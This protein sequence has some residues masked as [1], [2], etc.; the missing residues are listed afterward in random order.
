MATTSLPI[1]AESL[2]IVV[3]HQTWLANERIV[4]HRNVGDKLIYDIS[5]DNPWCNKF[6]IHTI[7]LYYF[8]SSCLVAAQIRTRGRCRLAWNESA[9]LFD[10][11]PLYLY[12]REI[13]S[14][15]KSLNRTSRPL[16]V[17]AQNFTINPE[18]TSGTTG[19]VGTFM[20][21]SLNANGG[22]PPKRR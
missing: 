19:K 16:L 14:P 9:G 6:E 8:V 1:K 17:L 15:I 13:T 7:Q 3:V 4:G 10:I 11:S 2:N 18:A 12:N 22:P 5:S 20:N 21:M